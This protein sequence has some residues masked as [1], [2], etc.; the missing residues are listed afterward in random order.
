MLLFPYRTG[1]KLPRTTWDKASDTVT[2]DL[3][4]G[5]V[6]TVT[7][8]RGADNRTRIRFVRH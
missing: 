8:N 5:T 6:D 3:Q 2:I 1:E 4:N 7:F